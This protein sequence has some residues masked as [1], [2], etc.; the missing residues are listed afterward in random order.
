MHGPLDSNRV[1]FIHSNLFAFA[2]LMNE[3]APWTSVK[4]SL[5]RACEINAA[6]MRWT[7]MEVQIPVE[8]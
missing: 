6:G 4:L 3:T 2:A 1:A 7:L 5:S 8:A